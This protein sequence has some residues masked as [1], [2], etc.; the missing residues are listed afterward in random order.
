[1][2]QNQYRAKHQARTHICQ[3]NQTCKSE[4]MFQISLPEDMFQI[5]FP[6]EKHTERL[7]AL[8]V[9]N[10]NQNPVEVD[11]FRRRMRKASDFP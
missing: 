11:I 7:E 9:R 5:S 6:E 1:M 4:D 2:P 8:K 10:A 3:P